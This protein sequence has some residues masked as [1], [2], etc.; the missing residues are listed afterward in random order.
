[1]FFSVILLCELEMNFFWILKMLEYGRWCWKKPAS[2]TSNNVGAVNVPFQIFTIMAPLSLKWRS[3]YS[4]LS[5]IQH[6]Q[7]REKIQVNGF[8]SDQ[9]ANRAGF[10]SFSLI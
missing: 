6:P 3:S 4:A 5:E 1:M 9:G 2:D 8:F 7:P 10:S